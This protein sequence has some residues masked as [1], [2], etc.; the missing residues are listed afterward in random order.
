MKKI[1]ALLLVLAMSAFLFA[2]CDMRDTIIVGYT[3]YKPMNY[4]NDNG[5]LVGFDTDL[6]KAVF[7]DKLGY[8]VIFKEIKWDQKYLELDSG[9]IDCI[10]NGMT[11]TDELQK[12]ILV[13]NSYLQNRQVVVLPKDDV[14]AFSSVYE[15]SRVALE[16][17]GAA[18]ALLTA[19]SLPTSAMCEAV[20]QSSA[21]AEVIGGNA[22]VAVVDYVMAKHLVGKGVYSNLAFV[23]MEG[24][25]DEF[26][27]IGFRNADAELCEKVDGLIDKYSK[28]GTFDALKA[29]YLT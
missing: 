1:L 26:F 11:V 29:K 24:A 18:Q 21:L 7:E 20:T 23:E 25:P 17:G 3:V 13:S 10:W 5:E 4:E 19:G 2:S 8:K 28:N 12:Q 6:A 9:T 27:A 16:K 15:T 22:D 14:A